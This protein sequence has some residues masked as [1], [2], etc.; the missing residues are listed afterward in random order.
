MKV[1]NLGP[2]Q[3]QQAFVTAEPHWDDLSKIVN[4]TPATQRKPASE[5]N[6]KEKKKVSNVG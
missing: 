1:L 3:G 2:L 5:K 6:K 4:H